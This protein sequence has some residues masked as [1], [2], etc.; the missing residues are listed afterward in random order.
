MIRA[1]P[2]EREQVTLLLQKVKHGDSS[3]AEELFRVL[4]HEL[5][6]MAEQKLKDQ[7]KG[8]TL[9][10]TALVNEAYLR[11]IGQEGGLWEGRKAFFAVASRAMRSVL[12]DHARRKNAAKRDAGARTDLSDSLV[13]ADDPSLD[14]VAL[15]EALVRLEE[16][17]A[18]LAKIVDLLFFCG[19]TAEEASTVLDCSS[20]TVERGWRTARAWLFRQ[21]HG[22]GGSGPQPTE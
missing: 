1:V 10:P 7:P 17:D 5:H 21:L 18:Q 9:Q 16:F 13:W 19:L 8:H 15:D 4:A 6:A 3:A 14:L 12:V 20:R 22:P 2:G 11:L